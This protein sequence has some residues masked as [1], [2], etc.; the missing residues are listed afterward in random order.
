MI[1]PVCRHI[2]E[3]IFQIKEVERLS[4]KTVEQAILVFGDR[5]KNNWVLCGNK[6]G[7]TWTQAPSVGNIVKWIMDE[8]ITINEAVVLHNHPSLP[9]HG[10]IVPSNEDI[11]STEFLKWQLV[12]L[13]IKLIDH[14]IITGS[15]KRSLWEMQVYN[16]DCVKISG[17]EIKR[18]LY[19]FLVQISAILKYNRELHEIIEALEKNLDVLRPYYEESFFFRVLNPKPDDGRFKARL[20]MLKTSDSLLSRF[21][22]VLMHLED[23]RNFKVHPEKVIP[24]GV[25]LQKKIIKLGHNLSL[26]VKRGGLTEDKQVI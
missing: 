10:T 19:S 24:Y 8:Q 2:P 13:G 17:F 6:F 3:D 26:P 23:G 14:V 5:E 21:V 9:R 16:Y 7:E 22:D 18:F 20:A 25:E 11:V 12:L 15:Q 1:S 4:I